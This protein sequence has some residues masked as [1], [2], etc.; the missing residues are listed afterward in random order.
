MHAYEL[1][2]RFLTRVRFQVSSSSGGCAAAPWSLV[3]STLTCWIFS[4]KLRNRWL[5]WFLK[6]SQV[7]FAFVL[8]SQI[9]GKW[10]YDTT[11]IHGDRRILLGI[12]KRDRL[13]KQLHRFTLELFTVIWATTVDVAVW[14]LVRV[15]QG[16]FVLLSGFG[17]CPVVNTVYLTM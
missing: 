2:R 9:I 4:L 16:V 17:S 1:N 7:I 6:C 12:R 10:R 11:G 8:L 3:I 5:I 14:Q 13:N 15:T